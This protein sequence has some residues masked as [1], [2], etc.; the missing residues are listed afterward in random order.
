M[1]GDQETPATRV[2]VTRSRSRSRGARPPVATT[3]VSQAPLSPRQA[4]TARSTPASAMPEARRGWTKQPPLWTLAAVFLVMLGITTMAVK[5]ATGGASDSS[6]GTD[7]PASSSGSLLPSTFD[8]V[9]AS[10]SHLRAAAEARPIA[11]S[12]AFFAAYTFKQ[13]WCVPGSAVLNVLAGATFGAAW[14]MS[15][16]TAGTAVGVALLYGLSSLYGDRLFLNWCG[17]R[18]RIQ[19]LQTRVSQAAA[20]SALPPFLLSLRVVTIFPQWLVNI[21]A[22][23]VSIPFGTHAWTTPLGIAPYNFLGVRTGALLSTLSW[24][25]AL[26][27]GVLASFGALAAVMAGLGVYMKRRFGGAAAVGGASTASVVSAKA[28]Q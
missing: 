22:P 5:H 6:A 24:Q 11:W 21:A 7:A 19:P 2:I 25:E 23:H 15:L 4:R 9:R 12:L 10:A 13:T 27:P 3:P 14:G 26:S 20:A 18:R 1:R 17:L 16:V 8:E 28:E